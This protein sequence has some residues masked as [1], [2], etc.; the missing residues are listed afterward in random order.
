MGLNLK[1]KWKS[2]SLRSGLKKIGD[3]HKLLYDPMGLF[4]SADGK[5]GDVQ[6]QAD[7]LG[8]GA[9]PKAAAEAA[10]TA[11]KAQQA[12]INKQNALIEEEKAKQE[13]V[14]DE[15]RTRMSK[16]Q[17]LSGSETGKSTLLGTR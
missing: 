13:K 14:L 6:Y 17:L 15:R 3:V 1:K 8:M 11:A 12:E 4:T 16:N 7:I 10:E 9:R 2:S 5:L